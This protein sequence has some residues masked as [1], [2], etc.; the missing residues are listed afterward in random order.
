[1]RCIISLFSLY[2]LT[3]TLTIASPGPR[4]PYLACVIPN[5]LPGETLSFCRGQIYRVRRFIVPSFVLPATCIDK[6]QI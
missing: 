3:D 1:M 5:L 2:L 4:L 6:S